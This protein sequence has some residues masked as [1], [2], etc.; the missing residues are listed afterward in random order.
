MST[1]RTDQSHDVRR[2][3]FACGGDSPSCI[4]HPLSSRA[5]APRKL[6]RQIRPAAYR[7]GMSRMRTGASE[8]G[9]KP[10]QVIFGFMPASVR[11]PRHP[12]VLG[13]SWKRQILTGRAT[14]GAHAKGSEGNSPRLKTLVFV[15][16]VC[17]R[18]S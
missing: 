8:T 15:P 1:S 13:Q 10:Q 9:W 17:L 14:E 16:P 5:C 11:R 7:S 2:P 18:R 6:S 4:C 3:L 12:N